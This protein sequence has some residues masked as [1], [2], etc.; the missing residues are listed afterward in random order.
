MRRLRLLLIG[1]LLAN[2]CA[3]DSRLP[4]PTAPS[5][6]SESG[7]A[8]GFPS[9]ERQGL[10]GEPD[11]S[12]SDDT[13]GVYDTAN[14]VFEELSVSATVPF[15]VSGVVTDK[16]VSAWTVAKAAVAIA[17]GGPTTTT[18]AQ[19]HYTVKVKAGTYTITVSAP[20]YTTASVKKALKTTSIVSFALTPAKPAGASARCKD[21]T[22]SFSKN[23]SGTCSWH[24]GVQY[25]V[26][27]GPLCS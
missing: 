26:C 4:L 20:G 17:P 11:E 18:S 10:V 8:I 5:N 9:A 19:G 14:I 23:R 12:T 22:W 3:G 2:S 16:M 24:K 25:W 6:A 27:P 7:T 15:A 1:A 21:R 13:V